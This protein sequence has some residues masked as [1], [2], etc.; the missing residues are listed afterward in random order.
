M[1]NKLEPKSKLQRPKL[2]FNKNGA[3]SAIHSYLCKNWNVFIYSGIKGI[4]Y[5]DVS[6]NE[7]EFNGTGKY[8]IHGKARIWIE[9]P[10]DSGGCYTI[11]TNYSNIPIIIGKNSDDEPIVKDIKEQIILQ[12]N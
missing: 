11:D 2:E 1:R 7:R 3:L 5:L 10:V 6:F 8:F 9:A 12:K 4:D